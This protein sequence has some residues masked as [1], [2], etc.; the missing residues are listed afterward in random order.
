LAGPMTALPV[1]ADLCA[2]FNDCRSPLPDALHPPMKMQQPSVAY[3]E[4]VMK[5]AFAMYPPFAQECNKDTMFRQTSRARGV[6][7]E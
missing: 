4:T 3:I 1:C 2:A 7:P 5:Y 6:L